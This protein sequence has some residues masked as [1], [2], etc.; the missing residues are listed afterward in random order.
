MFSNDIWLVFRPSP[1][2]FTVVLTNLGGFPPLGDGG[3][4]Y[5]YRFIRMAV[6][7]PEIRHYL[8]GEAPVPNIDLHSFVHFPYTPLCCAHI[9]R[10]SLSRCLRPFVSLGLHG[11]LFSSFL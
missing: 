8:M 9:V 10:L 2:V 3:R 4:Q 6:L 7:T 11:S 5:I 1:F